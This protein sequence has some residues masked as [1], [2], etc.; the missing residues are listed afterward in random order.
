M[1]YFKADEK[2][3]KM[4]K[5]VR[6]PIETLETFTK[7][8]CRFVRKSSNSATNV[9]VYERFATNFDTG[10]EYL[11]CLEVVKGIPYTQPNGD[12]IHLYPSDEQ[13]GV[14]GKSVDI[15]KYT[16]RIVEYLV[17]NPN[18]WGPEEYHNFKI[19]LAYGK[20]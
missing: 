12:K 17:N 19:S 18:G 16:D 5:T 1:A 14:Y 11:M 13:F 3:A 20:N 9:Y 2:L 6:T 8:G 15:N 4:D 10:K 7:Y